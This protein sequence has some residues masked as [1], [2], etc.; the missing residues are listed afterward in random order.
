MKSFV[1][2]IFLTPLLASAQPNTKMPPPTATPVSVSYEN[3]LKCFPELKD[4][5]LAFKVNLTKLKELADEKFVTIRSQLRQ[6]KVNYLDA[7][8]Q[9]FNLIL[10]NETTSIKKPK[11]ELTVQ[12]VQADGVLTDIA[13]TKN[14]RTNPKQEIINGF[15]LN[16]TI[17]SDVY[18][19]LDTKLNGVSSTYKRNFHEVTEFNLE[20]SARKRSLSCSSESQLGIICTC[21]K[22]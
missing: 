9:E 2:F 4:D 17:R 6:R 5:S 3:V 21:T 22:K 15:L 20:G 11:I 19:Y 13:L 18:S 16:S 8:K 12:K 7:D 14:Q 10:K 1:P